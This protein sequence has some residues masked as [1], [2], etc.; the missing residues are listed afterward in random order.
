MKL[1]PL[2]IGVC[3]AALALSGVVVAQ[4]PDGATTAD[5]LNRRQLQDPIGQ[6]IRESAPT[7]Q[8]AATP[9]P[10]ASTPA[11]QADEEADD[12]AEE[13][14]A[15]DEIVVTKA[16]PARPAGKRQR[17]PV[18]VIR[19]IDKI[20]A[21]TMTFEV[22]VGGPPVRFNGLIF[23][24]RACEL[25]A[26]DEAV[27]DAVAYMEVRAQPRGAQNISQARQVFRGWMF[28]SSPAV[29]GLEHPIYDAWVVDC[30]T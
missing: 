25:S 28:A 12:E 17:R 14:K 5:D 8:P 20:T 27:D 29:S 7:P 26:S 10:A 19:A 13:E 11:A 2:L 15:S 21:E 6:V 1:R 9:A 23:T 16:A 30:K 4:D 24:A 18:A 3:A 22:R